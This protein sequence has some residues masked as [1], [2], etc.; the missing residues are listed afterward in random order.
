[1]NVTRNGKI[2][3]KLCILHF[4]VFYEKKLSKIFFKCQVNSKSD[5]HL[6]NVLYFCNG[7]LKWRQNLY[8]TNNDDGKIQRTCNLI[9][10]SYFVA[11]N[12]KCKL[13]LHTFSFKI[14]LSMCTIIKY[15]SGWRNN[16]FVRLKNSIVFVFRHNVDSVDITNT[17]GRLEWFPK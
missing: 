5:V 8:L 15:I 6:L 2:N 11:I 1:M 10:R 13:V 12:I 4:L 16:F 3:N 14:E 9:V 17:F 7:V